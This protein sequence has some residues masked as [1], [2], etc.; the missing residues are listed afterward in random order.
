MK[1]PFRLIREEISHDTVECL[2]QLR[3]MA[4]RGELIGI[5]FVAMR[6]GRNFLAHAT[7]ETYRNPTFTRGMLRDLDDSLGRIQI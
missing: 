2:D 1:A 7:G 4:Q 6:K 5:A 3:E